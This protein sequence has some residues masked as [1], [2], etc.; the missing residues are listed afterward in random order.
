MAGERSVAIVA[1][2]TDDDLLVIADR[3]G[4]S[5]DRLAQDRASAAEMISATSCLSECILPRNT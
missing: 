3:Y 1:E 2:W 5:L 4:V